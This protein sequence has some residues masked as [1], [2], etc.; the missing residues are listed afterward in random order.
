MQRPTRAAQTRGRAGIEQRLVGKDSAGDSVFGG[1][2]YGVRM[3]E[4]GVS[5]LPPPD[6]DFQHRRRHRRP[7][8]P[9]LT[10]NSATA[11]SKITANSKIT[12]TNA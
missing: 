9:A 1:A 4:Y 5:Y 2:E 12:N 3:A 11:A 6:Y 7:L 8:R 10:T